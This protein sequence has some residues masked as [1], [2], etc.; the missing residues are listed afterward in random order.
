M[1]CN[2][3]QQD[4]PLTQFYER[5]GKH[6][7]TGRYRQPCAVCQR[8]KALAKYHEAKESDSLSLSTALSMRREG[9]TLLDTMERTGLR[10]QYW[11]RGIAESPR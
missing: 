4:R 9:E 1:I 6:K 8:A 5:G 7:G 3:C 10:V 11:H 2:Q